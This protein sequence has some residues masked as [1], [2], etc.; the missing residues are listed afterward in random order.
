MGRGVGS[1][2]GEAEAEGGGR[3]GARGEREGVRARTGWERSCCSPP[4]RAAGRAD[5]LR[6]A[7]QT[8]PRV[9]LCSRRPRICCGSVCRPLE[10]G[11]SRTEKRQ[12]AGGGG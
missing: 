3:E 8:Q 10:G 5:S 7:L 9:A 6:H 12:W 11:A 4:G 2:R 1:G